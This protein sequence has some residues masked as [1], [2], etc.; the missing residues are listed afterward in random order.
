M[1]IKKLM[2]IIIITVSVFTNSCGNDYSI[3]QKAYINSIEKHRNEKNETFKNSPNSPFN[4]RTKVEFHDLNYFDVNPEF[5]FKSKLFE[6]PIR[7]LL[8]IISI[9]GIAMIEIQRPYNFK[10]Q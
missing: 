7:Q 1:N 4:S 3:E 2:P 5:V 8:P 10:S 6:Y 9:F